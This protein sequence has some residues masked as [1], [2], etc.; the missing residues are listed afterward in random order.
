MCAVTLSETD[1]L[2]FLREGYSTREIAKEYGLPPSEVARMASRG[3]VREQEEKPRILPP[4]PQARA[5]AWAA[6]LDLYG[7]PETAR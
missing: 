2:G 6:G 4:D 3:A 1:I 5:K 7:R